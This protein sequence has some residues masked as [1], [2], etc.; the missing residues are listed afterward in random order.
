MSKRTEKES[1]RNTTISKR[2]NLAWSAGLIGFGLMSGLLTAKLRL[3]SPMIAGAALLM[4]SALIMAMGWRWRQRAEI[5]RK[6]TTKAPIEIG[7]S[8]SSESASL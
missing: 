4:S 3:Y 6:T 2:E 1:P 8:G 5:G 7:G